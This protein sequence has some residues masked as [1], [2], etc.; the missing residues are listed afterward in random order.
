MFDKKCRPYELPENH[1]TCGTNLLSVHSTTDKEQI[2]Q[3]YLHV[4]FFQ[5]NALEAVRKIHFFAQ[6]MNSEMHTLM[7]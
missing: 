6:I 3:E 1:D 5:Q 2:W 4:Q 7:Y